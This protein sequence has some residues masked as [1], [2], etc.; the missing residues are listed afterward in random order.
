MNHGSLHAPGN[1]AMTAVFRSPT[2]LAAGFHVYAIDWSKDGVW[3]SVD[4]QV[5][6]TQSAADYTGAGWPFDHP[7][8]IF[9]NVAVG[10]NFGGNPDS[11]TTFPQTML[12]DY[13]RVYSQAP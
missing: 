1:A 13:V 5:Y 7:F 12:V 11:T 9:L 3:F 10:G 8:F 6:E 2:S 4:G